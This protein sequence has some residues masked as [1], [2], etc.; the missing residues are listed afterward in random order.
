MVNR[1]F[2]DLKR[3]LANLDKSTREKAVPIGLA[4]SA[5]L[6]QGYAKKMAPAN[7]GELRQ[8]IL[9]HTYKRGGKHTAEVYAAV[10]YAVFVEF[11]TGPEGQANHSG[12][13]PNISVN[14]R[15]TPWW[16]HESDISKQV[17]EKYHFPKSISV[18]GEAFYWTDG[19][20][21]QPFMYQSGE[22][23]RPKAHAIFM[24]TIREAQREAS[25]S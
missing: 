1:D 6:I 2:N 21:A 8:K 3:T 18:N 7:N 10:R 25:F 9:T 22:K 12:T 20:K 17:V 15:S 14:Y 16:I 11:G 24:K 19:Q 4:R 23:A 13:N 5:K